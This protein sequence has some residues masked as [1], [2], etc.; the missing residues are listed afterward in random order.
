MPS[1]INLHHKIYITNITAK[2][3]IDKYTI[4]FIYIFINKLPSSVKKFPSVSIL[5]SPTKEAI[6]GHL[7]PITHILA[8]YLNSHSSKAAFLAIVRKMIY[9]FIGYD[10]RQQPRAYNAFWNYIGRLWCDSHRWFIFVARTF[11]VSTCIFRT[12]GFL[13]PHLRNDN[14]QSFGCFF[15]YAHQFMATGTVFVFFGYVNN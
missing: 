8:A 10:K 9:K 7:L 15:A 6:K 2:S 12:Y 11:T 4:I 13:N 3:N 14:L 1:W 5:L